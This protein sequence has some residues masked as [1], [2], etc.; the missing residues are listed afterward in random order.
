[1]ALA[2]RS[3][4]SVFQ[5]ILLDQSIIYTHSSNFI[6]A[7][8]VKR[9]WVLGLLVAEVGFEFQDRSSNLIVCQIT[10]NGLRQVVYIVL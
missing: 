6:Y 1:M 5:D 9:T 3:M 7:K 4:R 10:N 2:G 8:I